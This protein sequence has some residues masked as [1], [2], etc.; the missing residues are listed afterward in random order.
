MN[1]NY[2]FENSTH[3]AF[4]L[5]SDKEPKKTFW[6]FKMMKRLYLTFWGFFND[7]AFK[8]SNQRGS[9]IDKMYDK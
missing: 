6:L 5:K 2:L 8:I 7:L 3:L 4:Q 9:P 1:K